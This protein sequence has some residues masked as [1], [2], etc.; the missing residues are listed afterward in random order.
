MLNRV[1]FQLRIYFKNF[2]TVYETEKRGAS[3]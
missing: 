3:A 2:S 1:E